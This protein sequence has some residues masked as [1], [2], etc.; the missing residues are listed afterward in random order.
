MK[1]AEQII[2]KPVITEKSSLL[3]MDSVYV[4]SVLK[5]ATKIDIKNAVE[6]LFK[7]NV[8]SVNTAKVRGKTRRLGKSVG[9]TS[10]WKKAYVKLEQGQKIDM[11]EGMI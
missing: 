10:G 7:V 6:K 5:D 2:L 4:F 11:I 8:V 1:V 3:K 9:T